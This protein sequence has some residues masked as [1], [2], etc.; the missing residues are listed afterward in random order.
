MLGMGL[1]NSGG[2]VTFSPLGAATTTGGKRTA[3]G[4]SRPQV[5]TRQGKRG[6]YVPALVLLMVTGKGGGGMLVCILKVK[7][8]LIYHLYLSRTK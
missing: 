7:T 5:K 2:R 8:K 3:G 1:T 6:L 4:A